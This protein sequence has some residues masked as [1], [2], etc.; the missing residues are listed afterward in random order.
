MRAKKPQVFENPDQLV[1]GVDNRSTPSPVLCAQRVLLV[2]CVWS[3]TRLS[4]VLQNVHLDI[5]AANTNVF[6]LLLCSRPEV[7]AAAQ[8]SLVQYLTQYVY[9]ADFCF[10]N[11]Q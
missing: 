3:L 1:W 9:E 5:R 8:E 2:P 4:R 7:L 11:S 6:A 10:R